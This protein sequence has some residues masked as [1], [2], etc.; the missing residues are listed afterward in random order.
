MQKGLSHGR[1]CH[2]Q[3]QEKKKWNRV[4]P[5]YGVCQKLPQGCIVVNEYGRRYVNL[6]KMRKRIQENQSRALLWKGSRKCRW[7][8]FSPGREGQASSKTIE[9]YNPWFRIWNRGKD[10]V[11]YA[12]ILSFRPLSFFCSLQGTCEPI[13]WKWNTTDLRKRVGRFSH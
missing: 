10:S 2:R 6:S 1:G 12:Y 11:E 5:L 7:I 8:Y 9:G 3:L 13:Y 4:H